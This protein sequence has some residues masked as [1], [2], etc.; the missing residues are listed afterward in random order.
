VR[1]VMRKVVDTMGDRFSKRLLEH[2][3]VEERR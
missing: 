1:A 2:L 3:G